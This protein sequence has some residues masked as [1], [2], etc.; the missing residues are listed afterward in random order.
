[1]AY[2]SLT[3]CLLEAVDRYRNRRSMMYKAGNRWESLSAAE[4]LRRIAGLSLAL[5]ELG[6]KPGDRVGLF[7]PNRPEW[8]IVDF[9]ILGLGAINVPIYFNES[10]ERMAYILNHSGTKVV[11]TAGSEQAR[12]LLACRERLGAG[13][14]GIVARAPPEIDGEVLVFE[15]LNAAAG[16][17]QVAAVRRHA[18]GIIALQV[19]TRNYISRTTRP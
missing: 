14:Q 15:T 8:H 17:S 12:R 18:G 13:E 9:A 6:V 2:P 16:R 1:M 7:S 11:I 3:R 19:A 5:A 10:P 4:M